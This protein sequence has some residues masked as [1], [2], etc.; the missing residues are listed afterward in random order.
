LPRHVVCC[1]SRHELRDA[2]RPDHGR[3]IPGR[4]QQWA[5]PLGDPPTNKGIAFSLDE[6]ERLGLEG[7]LP[8]AVATMTQQLERVYES[9]LAKPTSLEHYIYLATQRRPVALSA[10]CEQDR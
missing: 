10:R 8:P 1:G 2:N 4:R 7:L 5:R 6:R 3:G 9:F